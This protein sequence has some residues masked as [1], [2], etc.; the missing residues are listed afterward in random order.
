MMSPDFAPTRMTGRSFMAECMA[1]GSCLSSGGGAAPLS[2]SPARAESEE[3]ME[4]NTT[5]HKVRKTVLR[6]ACEDCWIMGKALRVLDRIRIAALKN[7]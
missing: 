6:E 4:A 1:R 3:A 7:G 5:A 2:V